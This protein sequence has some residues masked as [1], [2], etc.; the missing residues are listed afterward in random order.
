MKISFDLD[1]TIIP[2]SNEFEVEDIPFLGKLIKAERTRAGTIEL[3]KK[4]RSKKWEIWIYTTSYRSV[5]QI[6]KTFIAHGLKTT[7]IING[8]ISQ[9]TLKKHNCYASKNPKLFGIDLHVDDLEGVKME[10]EKYQFETLIVDL[11]EQNWINLVLQRI[12]QIE[13]KT[14]YNK[15]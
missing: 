1:N 14:N 11:K 15:T 7:R 2:Y 6:K 5:W 10:G 9:D 12:E 8:K 13:K 3:F 4:L